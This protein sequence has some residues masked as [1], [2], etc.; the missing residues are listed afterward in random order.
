MGAGREGRVDLV[1]LTVRDREV[2]GERGVVK[3][4]QQARETRRCWL[5]GKEA[6]GL[7]CPQELW[8]PAFDPHRTFALSKSGY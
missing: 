6:E 3:I 1:D 8:T 4:S 2:L 5:L 7:S